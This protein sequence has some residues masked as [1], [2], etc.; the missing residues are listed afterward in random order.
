MVD[1]RNSRKKVNDKD[2]AEG[3]SR[4]TVGLGITLKEV[5]IDNIYLGCSSYICGRSFW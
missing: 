4:L 5:Q 2:R 3:Q 1:K